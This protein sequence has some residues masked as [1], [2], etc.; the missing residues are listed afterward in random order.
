LLDFEH[1]GIR[2]TAGAGR[3]EDGRLAETFLTTA[4]YGTAVDV[5]ARDGA[6]AAPLLLQHGCPLHTLHRALTRNSDDATSGPLAHALDLLS[7]EGG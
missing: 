2:Y 3:F 5:S 4:K 7:A 1:G 6:V